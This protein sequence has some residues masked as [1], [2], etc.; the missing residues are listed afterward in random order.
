MAFILFLLLY[1]ASRQTGIF[2]HYGL[3]T[4]F[5]VADRPAFLVICLKTGILFISV[6]ILIISQFT[7]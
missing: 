6:Y 1:A 5:V 3:H 4:G 7:H 2:I